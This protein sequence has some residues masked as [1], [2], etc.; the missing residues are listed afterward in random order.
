[1]GTWV[2]EGPDPF[3]FEDI[4]PVTI[5][6]ITARALMVRFDESQHEPASWIPKSVCHLSNKRWTVDAEYE[7]FWV[8]KWWAEREGFA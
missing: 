8:A 6:W 7:E 1:M 4:G 3:A 5:V 2:G